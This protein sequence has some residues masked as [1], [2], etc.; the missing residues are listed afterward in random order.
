MRV[1][2]VNG[3]R[4]VVLSLLLVLPA[5]SALG[6]IINQNFMIVDMNEMDTTGTVNATGASNSASG[7]TICRNGND[8]VTVSCVTTHP[9]VVRLIKNTAKL[10]QGDVH[11]Q[12]TL[13][14]IGAGTQ[15]FNV[16]LS[17]G[18]LAFASQINYRAIPSVGKFRVLG[19][20]CEGLTEARATY[21]MDTCAA[22][23]ENKTIRIRVDGPT[24]K[25]LKLR[26]KGDAF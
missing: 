6:Q 5:A 15:A 16:V 22:D 25:S 26:A 8:T 2:L 1:E 17:C 19:G 23:T 3:T 9:E 4:V 21:L 20:D 14:V 11:N 10:Q 7:Q 13:R 18:R 24:L 12:P